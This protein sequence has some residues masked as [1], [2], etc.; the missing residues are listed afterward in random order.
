MDL[1][2]FASALTSDLAVLFVCVC[3]R[4]SERVRERERKRE[5]ACNKERRNKEQGM[6]VG[7]ERRD[8]LHMWSILYGGAIYIVLNTYIKHTHTHYIRLASGLLY[9]CFTAALLL[10]YLCKLLLL[11]IRLANGTQTRESFPSKDK[12]TSGG[13]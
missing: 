12:K 7:R 8:T 9:Y 13:C 3:E 2:N 5:R 6:N 10:L 1:L 11:Y 4:E